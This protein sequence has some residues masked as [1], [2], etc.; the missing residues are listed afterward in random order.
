MNC[1]FLQP[2]LQRV[3]GPDEADPHP[4]PALQGG[5]AGRASLR[6][7]RTGEGGEPRLHGADGDRGR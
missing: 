7:R 1:F 2:R 6:P 5:Q 4:G 3:A